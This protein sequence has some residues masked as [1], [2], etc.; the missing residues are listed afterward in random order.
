M[1]V[2]ISHKYPWIIR[3]T[4]GQLPWVGYHFCDIKYDIKLKKN[5]VAVWS[6]D[7]TLSKI[8]VPMMEQLRD[9]KHGY[10]SCIDQ[11][12]IPVELRNKEYEEWEGGEDKEVTDAYNWDLGMKQW[13]WI[14]NEIIWAHTELASDEEGEMQFYNFNDSPTDDILYDINNIEVDEEGLKLYNERIENALRLFGKYYR[15][16]WW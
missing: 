12:D 2:N 4:L 11:N 16:L 7:Y 15:A 3:R 13:E 10:P 1:K 5:D 14:L 6:A 9:V 8:I